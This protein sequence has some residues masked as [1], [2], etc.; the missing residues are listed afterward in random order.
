MKM[1]VEQKHQSARLPAEATQVRRFGK[2]RSAQSNVLREDYVELVADL[3]AVEGEARPTGIA[4]RLGVSHVTAV[5]AIARLKRGGLVVGRPYCGV[6]LTKSGK[7]LARR[8]KLRHRI[9]VDLLVAV[10]VPT[11]A[12]ETDAEGIEHHVSEA[13][14]KAFGRY[15][16]VWESCEQRTGSASRRTVT[17]LRELTAGGG[18]EEGRDNAGDQLY[19]CAGWV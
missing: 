8:V 12:A 13:T 3:L 7:A 19:A 2:A 1:T 18:I 9:V 4:R 10:G 5:R 14:L 15:L 11:E 16:Q 17:S 6:F